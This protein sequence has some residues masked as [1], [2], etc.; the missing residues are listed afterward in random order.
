[1]NFLYSTVVYVGYIRTRNFQLFQLVQYIETNECQLWLLSDLSGFQMATLV[2]KQ[3]I[4]LLISFSPLHSQLFFYLCTLFDQTTP[5]TLLLF[6]WM[7]VFETDMY[8]S[9]G[10]GNGKKARNFLYTP[11]SYTKITQKVIFQRRGINFQ[12]H[13]MPNGASIFQFLC[14]VCYRKLLLKYHTALCIRWLH[15][16]SRY[17]G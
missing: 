6:I 4:E 14:E 9:R 3:A 7:T 1:M 17:R 5:S 12:T 8:V 16:S 2:E 11:P 10:E 15:Y 13:S